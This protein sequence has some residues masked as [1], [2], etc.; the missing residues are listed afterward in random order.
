MK[1]DKHMSVIEY[2]HVDNFTMTGVQAKKV[3]LGG[4][5]TA[6]NMPIPLRK[7]VY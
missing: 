2:N 3:F 5:K 1:I 4:A 7:I 6:K